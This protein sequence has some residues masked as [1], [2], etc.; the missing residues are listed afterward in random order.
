MTAGKAIRA[1]LRKAFQFSGRSCRAEYW[2][3]LPV[4]LAIFAAGLVLAS[5][6][7][8][9]HSWQVKVGTALVAL[10]PIC[11]VSCRRLADTGEARIAFDEPAKALAGFL[12][13]SWASGALT[14]WA[15]DATAGADGPAGFVVFLFWGSGMIVL[16][17]VAIHQF[18]TG[19]ILGSAL[20]SQ[21]AEP[22]QPGPNMYGP[23]PHEV[24]P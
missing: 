12:L 4:G 17:P 1:G 6:A 24:T 2:W 5:L 8:P 7:L 18:A 13:A 21:M 15:N 16:V 20:F 22:S 23:N 14:S 3:F 9:E 10:L 19:L 11:A